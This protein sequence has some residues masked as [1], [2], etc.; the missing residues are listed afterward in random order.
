MLSELVI[1][2]FAI[3]DDIRINFSRG[4]CVLTGETGAGKSIII[5]AVN[6][7]LGGRASTD[8]VRTG[9]ESAEL[10]AYFEIDPS[11]SA[12]AILEEQ[13]IDPSEGLMIRRLISNTAKSRIFIN[14]RQASIQMLKQ[15][16]L[17]LA[18]ISS[19]HAHQELLNEDHHM[20]IL[21]RFAKSV[22]LREEVTGLYNDIV[23]LKKELQALR[24]VAGEENPEIEFLKFQISDIEDAGISP[25]EDA[26]LEEKRKQLMNATNIFNAL[27]NV[28]D[29]MH[30]REGSVIETITDMRNVLERFCPV[31][32]VLEPIT[33]KLDAIIFDLDDLTAEI[34]NHASGIDM[35]PESLEVVEQRLDRIQK[36][37]RKYGPTLEALFEQY[38]NFKA[39]LEDIGQLDKKI[40]RLENALHELTS[41]MVQKARLLSEMRKKAGERLAELAQI[42]LN[43]LEMEKA[44]FKVN[45]VNVP[46]TEGS[47]SRTGEDFKVFSTG[48]DQVSFLLSPNPGEDPKPLS[49]I[50]SGGELSRIVLALKAVLSKFESQQTLIFDEVDAGVGGATAEKVGL[51]LKSLSADHQ[52]ICITHLAQIAKY[53]DAQYRIF[54]EVENNRTSTSIIPL[55]NQDQ[56]VEEI[57]R[58]IA[59]KSISAAALNHAKDLLAGAQA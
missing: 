9:Q 11:S 49:R 27:L 12:A 8:V 50:A 34:R 14:S 37:K 42:Q 30:E 3:I 32:E 31:D 48:I 10:E 41:K 24:P 33:R 23:P 46:K 19:Q 18:G 13:G 52:V 15:V 25:G 20:D 17:N 22:P 4:L 56:R 6:L 39:R 38:D 5:Q 44:V 2:N 36:L 7:L 58:M 1:K 45:I 40:E 16:T 28:I 59:G 47:P 57:A 55:T 53:A 26:V 35:D 21:D 54:K 29:R 51:K 43:E